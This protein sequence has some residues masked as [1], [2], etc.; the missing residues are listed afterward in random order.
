M[1]DAGAL[2]ASITGG[3]FGLPEKSTRLNAP[4]DDATTA[5]AWTE[6]LRLSGGSDRFKWVGGGFYADARRAVRPEPHRERLRGSRCRRARSAI[7]E[8]IAPKDSLFFSDLD[9]KTRSVRPLWRRRRSPSRS[10]FTLT[11]G[12]RY[13]HYDEDKAQIFDGLFGAGADGKA[14]VA[15]RRTAKADGV[16]PRFIAS[17]RLTDSDDV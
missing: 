7:R 9:Y 13:Y 3:S 15:A 17:Y 11:G 2:T 1:R 14:P 10:R 6:E 8:P 5:R 4:L 16:A 12:L